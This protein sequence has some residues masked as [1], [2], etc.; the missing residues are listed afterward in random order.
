LHHALLLSGFISLDYKGKPE[1]KQETVNR[2]CKHDNPKTFAV[3]ERP[4]L[5]GCVFK[6]GDL[7]FKERGLNGI[8]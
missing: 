6:D 3:L 8:I 5:G 1:K 2:N 4:E 7:V